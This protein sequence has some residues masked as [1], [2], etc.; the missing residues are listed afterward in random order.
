M[1]QQS[2]LSP[3]GRAHRWVAL[4]PCAGVFAAGVVGLLLPG[5][6]AYSGSF[7]PFWL[8]LVAAAVAAVGIVVRSTGHPRWRRLSGALGWAGLLLM[9]WTAGGLV[10]DLLRVAGR[11]AP[12]LMPHEV[13]WPGL[14]TR[15]LALVAVVVLARRAL[16]GPPCPAPAHD[17]RW[18][19]FT[20]LALA[21]LYPALKTWWA[22]GGTLGLRWPGAD[23]LD[24]SFT[25]WLPAVP[26]LLA[27]ALSL[28]L[29][30]TPQWLPRRLL[31]LAGWSATGVVAT[32][33]TAAC[34]S[35][36]GG[37]IAGDA[38]F[39]EM[40]GWVFGL[41]YGSWFLWAVANG[42]ATRAYQS[43]SAA[44]P[45]STPARHAA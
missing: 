43:R 2:G 42:A 32:V 22:L 17:A 23:D 9:L 18:Y 41:V 13:D 34:C 5:R 4:A 36:V 33:G 24:G 20:A 10:L 35:L 7:G 28:L 37:L 8:P 16:A 39:G 26:W 19:G 44:A 29:V 12:G 11:I 30:L 25:L 15:A 14:A 3:D 21:L 38:D 6:P 31:L 27:A 45:A 1:G 40:S